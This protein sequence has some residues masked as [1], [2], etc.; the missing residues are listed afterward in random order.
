MGIRSGFSIGCFFVSQC[1]KKFKG[2]PLCISKIS[3]NEIFH[4]QEGGI[5]ILSLLLSHKNEKFLRGKPCVPEMFWY[6]KQLVDKRD[7][8]TFLRWKF[9]Y[10]TVSTKIRTGTLPCFEISLVMEL[11][12]Q[13]MGGNH[14]LLVFLSKKFRRGTLCFGNV[15]V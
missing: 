5:T 2:E 7:G 8:I 11:F 3:G 13:R 1:R 9:F 15:L 14:V 4:A 12:M 10:L 6:G